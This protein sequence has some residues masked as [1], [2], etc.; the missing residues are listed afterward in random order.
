MEVAG[1]LP[2]GSPSVVVWEADGTHGS[3][4]GYG[5]PL[6]RQLRQRGHHVRVVALVERAP[7]AEEL[8]APFHLL[9]GGNTSATSD[10][11]WVCRARSALSGVLDRA[12]Q[13][14]ADVV[15]IC[16]GAQ[17]LATA[18]CG[19]RAVGPTAA[20]M[21]VGLARVHERSPGTTNGRSRVVAEFHHHEIAADAIR[22]AGATVTLTNE[23]TEVQAFEVGEHVVG[24]QFHPEWTPADMAATIG[25]CRRL[26]VETGGCA[27]RGLAT[28]A[29]R[30]GHWDPLTFDRLVASRFDGG[31]HVGPAPWRSVRS[32]GTEMVT[33]S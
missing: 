25:R 3:G 20:G 29:D 18:L 4:G 6:A 31:A 2:H 13:R 9:S 11:E 16:F 7:D 26:I 15:G 23:H 10:A 14:T 32:A 24:Y 33:T 12:L 5:G 19:Q 21:E 8:T 22:R 30:Y 17:L 27:E 1:G 28:V